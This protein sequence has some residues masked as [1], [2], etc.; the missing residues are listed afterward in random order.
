MHSKLFAK[1]GW[2]KSNQTSEKKALAIRNVKQYK[3]GPVKQ[4]KKDQFEL[5]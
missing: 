4:T 2:K 1:D 3:M 5:K